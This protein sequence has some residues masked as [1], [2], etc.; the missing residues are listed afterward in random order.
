MLRSIVMVQVVM[1]KKRLAKL[2]SFTILT[3]CNSLC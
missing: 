2:V 3:N 1:I